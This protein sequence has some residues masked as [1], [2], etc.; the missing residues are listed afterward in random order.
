[1]NKTPIFYLF[2]SF[3]LNFKI[4]VKFVDFTKNHPVL[5]DLYQF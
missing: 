4:S 1:M 2:L 5:L 3:R